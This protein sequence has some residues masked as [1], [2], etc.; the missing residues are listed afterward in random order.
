QVF[1]V[2]PTVAAMYTPSQKVA[3]SL[4]IFSSFYVGTFLV[5]TWLYLAIWFATS[6]RNVRGLAKCMLVVIALI[7]IPTERIRELD[8]K[9]H[10]T[11][12]ESILMWAAFGAWLKYGARLRQ[13]SQIEKP[14]IAGR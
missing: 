8:P 13:L 1:V 5:V 2:P 3:A 4:Y 12:W 6:E 7:W 9:L 14:S 10:L 11:L